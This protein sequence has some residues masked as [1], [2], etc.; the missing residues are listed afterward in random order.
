M[1]S[2]AELKAK[3][4]LNSGPFRRG[5]RKLRGFTRSFSR[6][7]GAPM[8]AATKQMVR[9]G[10]IAA[11]VLAAGL[12]VAAKAVANFLDN[13]DKMNLRTGIATDQL[14]ALSLASELAGSKLE[15]VEKAQKRLA[16]NVVDA[17]RGLKTSIDNFKD[18]GIEFDKFKKLSPADQF[19]LILKKIGETKNATVKLG[20]A[21]KVFGKAGAALIPMI[22]NLEEAERLTKKFGLNITPEQ[23]RQGADFNDQLTLIKFALK[24]LFVTAIGFKDLNKGLAAFRERIVNLRKS[25]GFQT[26]V[27]AFKNGVASIVNG[28]LTLMKTF[29]ILATSQGQNFRTLIKNA[30]ITVLFLKSGFLMPIIRIMGLVGLAI[31]RP[32]LLVAIPALTGFV[33]VLAALKIGEALEKAFD[34]SGFILKI[35]SIGKAMTMLLSLGDKSLGEAMSKSLQQLENDFADID[36][37]SE[38]VPFGQ[39]MKEAY[40]EAFNEIATNGKSA[41]DKIKEVITGTFPISKG[42]QEAM[43]AWKKAS[44]EIELGKDTEFAK[45]NMLDAEGAMQRMASMGQKF[46]GGFVDMTKAVAKE[47][48]GKTLAELKAIQDATQKAAIRAKLIQGTG[49]K[50]GKIQDINAAKK[51]SDKQLA[52][53]LKGLQKA[54]EKDT[55]AEESR[56]A[57]AVEDIRKALEIQTATKKNTEKMVTLLSKGTMLSVDK[58]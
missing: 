40:D 34:I 35:I 49:G 7:F 12:A 22:N 56:R 2:K 48:K 54:A 29:G 5:L 58:V 33:A 4:S 37:Q 20:L 14:V 11:T 52:S 50:A 6:N 57:K 26:F 3:V 19:S 53:F 17:N 15:D 10:V 25:Q 42:I 16:S 32:L 44:E 24:G 23:A 47:A 28:T 21:Q 46:R 38:K 36:A 27:T 55:R 41:M 39:A 18:L 8:A 1:A 9:M 51:I 45:N 30:A 31:A 13:I 43:D